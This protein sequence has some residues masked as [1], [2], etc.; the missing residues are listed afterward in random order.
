MTGKINVGLS[1][2]VNGRF[3]VNKKIVVDKSER[4]LYPFL[5]SVIDA[6]DEEVL[7]K[8]VNKARMAKRK[9]IE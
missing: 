3:I 6:H 9:A 5:Q 4:F 2:T 7:D 8:P 1:I